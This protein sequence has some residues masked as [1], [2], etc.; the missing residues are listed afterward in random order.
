MSIEDELKRIA[1]ILEWWRATQTVECPNCRGVGTCLPIQDTDD[2]A[3]WAHKQ[4]PRRCPICAGSGR[5]SKP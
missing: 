5:V 4:Y 1:D 2:P 3:F